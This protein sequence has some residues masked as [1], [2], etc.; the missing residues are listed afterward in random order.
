M[1]NN[2]EIFAEEDPKKI[3]DYLE[4]KAIFDYLERYNQ[5]IPARSNVFAYI[6]FKGIEDDQ[7]AQKKSGM[8]G[9]IS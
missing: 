2:A 6:Y 3:I 1:L 8:E 4:R 9:V 5:P 7:Q